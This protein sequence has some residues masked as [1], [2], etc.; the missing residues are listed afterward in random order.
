MSRLNLRLGIP[1]SRGFGLGLFLTSLEGLAAVALLACSAWLISAAAE[2]PPI[3]YLN[4]AIVGVRGFALGRAFFR[5]TQRLSLHDATFRLQSQL[6]PRI[7]SAVAPLAPAGLQGISRGNLT[8]RLI[9]DVEE[10]QNL[11]VRVVAPLVQSLV[12]SVASVVALAL[13]APTTAA[14][15]ILLV[16]LVVSA[17]LALPASAY[18]NSK[19]VTKATDAREELHAKSLEYLENQDLLQAYGWETPKLAALAELDRGL[20]KAQSRFAVTAGF[21]SAVFSLF[22][23]LAVCYLALA[24]AHG[25]EDRTLDHRML[26]VLALLPMAIFEIFTQL[27]PALFAL[28]RY[29]PSATRVADLLNATVPSSVQ[30]NAG[31]LELTAVTSIALTGACFSYPEGSVAVGPVSLNLSAG[32]SIAITG[33]SGAGKTTLAFGL[34]GFLHAT[35]GTV[36]VNGLQLATYNETSVR[37]RI[38]Y[39]EQ[40][41]TSFN[42]SLKANLLIGKPGATDEE[43]WEVLRR[44]G[45]KSVFEAREGLETPLGERGSAISGGEAQRIALARALLADFQVLIFDEPTANVDAERAEQL[46][47]D[48]VAIARESDTRI[49]IFIAHD[50]DFAEMGIPTLA[51]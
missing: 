1:R 4:M 43:L 6:R 23:T 51:L 11:G 19:Q 15:R 33:K 29:S 28:Q 24:G 39:L 9:N 46:W 45:L 18:F 13:L 36:E 26:A 22:S 41:P 47:A 14:W 16:T 32:D 30:P 44:V 5:Y 27:Q 12:V 38:G 3:L 49:S 35:T 8:S 17:V 7:F 20:A 42:A 50:R 2:Q 40:S 31:G 48:F 34:A 25:V 37:S 21:G 10:I